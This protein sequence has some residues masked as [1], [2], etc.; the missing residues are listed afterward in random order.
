MPSVRDL[1]F[2]VA[3]VA[4]III[5]NSISSVLLIYVSILFPLDSVFVK[6]TC[7]VICPFRQV[8]L[9]FGMWYCNLTMLC[10][11]V[12]LL[13]LPFVF[14]DSVYSNPVPFI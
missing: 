7:T 3:V 5:V 1:L 6:Y 10:I 9:F 4:I 12:M 2:K 11:L 13:V 14:M 8:Y